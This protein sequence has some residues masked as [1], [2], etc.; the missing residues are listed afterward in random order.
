[1][2]RARCLE[3]LWELDRPSFNVRLGE[4]MSRYLLASLLFLPLSVLAPTSGRAQKASRG[5]VARSAPAPTATET[6]KADT[7][8]S[9]VKFSLRLFAGRSEGRFR[10]WSG[11][12]TMPSDKSNAVPGPSDKWND[13]VVGV[14]IQATSVETD[15]EDRDKHLRTPD[16]FDVAK[17]PTIEFKSTRVKRDGD[18]LTIAGNLTIKNVTKPVVLKG[19]FLGAVP[20]TPPR[21]NFQATVTINRLDYGV[22]Y[23]NILVRDGIVLGEDVK[24]DVSVTAVRQ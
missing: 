15:D 5:I 9:A 20:G 8:S 14:V 18:S 23:E 7:S 24:I 13:A 17:Y 12:I 3:H 22:N 6:W 2:R 11:T 1:M 19:K 10:V 4:V 21:M 16:F